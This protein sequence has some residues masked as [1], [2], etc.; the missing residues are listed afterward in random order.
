MSY[1]LGA[2]RKADQERKRSSDINLDDWDNDDWNSR[3]DTQG[4]NTWLKILLSVIACIL[5]AI[6]ILLWVL[7]NGAPGSALAGA[8]PVV[9]LEEPSA[10]PEDAREGGAQADAVSLTTQIQEPAPQVEE[11]Q[12]FTEQASTTQ[13][14]EPTMPSLPEISG[15]LYFRDD[16]SLNRI[17]SKAGSYRVGDSVALGLVL[18]EITE[19]EAVF[20]WQNKTYEVR[21][22]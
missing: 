22:D 13:Q 20:E 6:F 21:F 17:F 3:D 15:H 5:V 19:D 7:L 14:V 9:V 8:E 12:G 2:L 11:R 4:L 10:R 18:V 1:I 16:V